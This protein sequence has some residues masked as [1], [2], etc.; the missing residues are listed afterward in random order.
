V[1]REA[2]QFRAQLG[3]GE[4]ILWAGKPAQGVL[5]TSRDILLI[6]FSI[7][8][9]GFVCVW[10]FGV[11]ST[12]APMEFLLVGMLFL[13]VGLGVMVGRFALD[14]F[15]RANTSYA[16]TTERVMINREG[17]FGDFTAIALKRLPT[18]KLKPRGGGRGTIVLGQSTSPW[19]QISIWTPSLDPTP[20]L[21]AIADAQ[22]VY[23]LIQKQSARIE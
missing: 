18:V 20:Q 5:F 14:A 9:L 17:P 2:D 10:L 15:V 11:V 4:S 23:A 21:I 19:V 16:V 22:R 3:P 12:G 8:W 1:S 13:V 7:F 6:P